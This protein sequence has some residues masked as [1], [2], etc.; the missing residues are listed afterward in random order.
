MNSVCQSGKFISDQVHHGPGQFSHYI[1]YTRIVG[2][3]DLG[4]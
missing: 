3:G 4:P 1:Y 2:L